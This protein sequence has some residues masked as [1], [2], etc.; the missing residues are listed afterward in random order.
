MSV[1]V[2]SPL[3]LILHETILKGVGQ[4]GA[5]DAGVEERGDGEETE[6]DTHQHLLD[7][8]DIS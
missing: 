5:V 4:D 6:R 3:C 7:R 2:S 8:G 1:V